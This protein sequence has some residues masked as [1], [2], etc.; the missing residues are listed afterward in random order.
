MNVKKTIKKI[1]AIGAGAALV[2][3][4]ILGAVA[5]LDNYPGNMVTEGMFNGKIVVG[6]NAATQDVVGAIDIAASL[7]AAA[8]TEVA[9]GDT[10]ETVTVEDGYEFTGATELIYGNS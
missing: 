1:V 7:Q 9:V 2:G 4:T 6:A 8:V 3:A 10:E 5:S